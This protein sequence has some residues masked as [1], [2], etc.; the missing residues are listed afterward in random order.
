MNNNNALSDA[1]LKVKIG[2][3]EKEECPQLPER[4]Y[5]NKMRNMKIDQKRIKDFELKFN[6]NLFK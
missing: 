5:K 1:D 2:D 4:E 3:D 6:K